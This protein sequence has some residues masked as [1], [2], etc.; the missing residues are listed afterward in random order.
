MASLSGL[1]ELAVEGSDLHNAFSRAARANSIVHFPT[2]VPITCDL[3]CF[4]S[5]VYCS[6]NHEILL[7]TVHAG[8]GTASSHPLPVLVPGERGHA[9]S[10]Q[11]SSGCHSE[12][13]WHLHAQ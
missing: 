7:F 9:G 1:W 11:C 10:E 8:N 5:S 3:I 13:E 4:Y 6:D 12:D 2:G